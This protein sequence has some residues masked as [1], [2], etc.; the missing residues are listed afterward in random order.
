MVFRT[1]PAH[2][3]AAPKIVTISEDAVVTLRVVERVSSGGAHHV[4]GGTIKAITDFEVNSHVVTRNSGV[5]RA[6]LTGGFSESGQS[7]VSLEEHK[8]PAIQ[9]ILCVLHSKYDD[10]SSSE[11]GKSITKA[12]IN[13]PV[14]NLWDVISSARHFLI[15]FFHLDE[16]FKLWY[17][18]NAGKTD[19]KDLLFP[20]FQFNHASG[21]A[22]ATNEVVYD[23]K[24][25]EET[26]VREHRDLHLPHH[27]IRKF[28][29]SVCKFLSN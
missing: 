22:L 20:C 12:T 2:K 16:W 13:L 8:A 9:V 7:T 27:V 3:A 21:F 24:R 18:A 29:Y 17:A 25:P 14:H 6:L 10:W 19:A 5:L 4:L 23:Y 26:K 28:N 1:R 11:L 15:E